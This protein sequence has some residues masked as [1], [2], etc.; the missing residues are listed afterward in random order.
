MN[1]EHCVSFELAKQLKKA[2][3]PQETEFYWCDKFPLVSSA[4]IIIDKITREKRKTGNGGGAIYF[5][6]LAVDALMN[7]IYPAPLAT[8]V[9]EELPRFIGNSNYELTI[10]HKSYG[11]YCV[12]FYDDGTESSYSEEQF[13]RSLPDALARMWLYLKK[14]ELLKEAK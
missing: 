10:V 1:I 5:E 9:L 12:S 6:K 14:E 4:P 2:E 8:E 13:D 7:N 3:Y 11:N